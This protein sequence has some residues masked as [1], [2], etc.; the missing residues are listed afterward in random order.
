MYSI[1]SC[2]GRGAALLGLG[3][4]AAM[5]LPVAGPVGAQPPKTGDAKPKRTVYA[6]KNGSAK[7]LAT[8]LGRFF[9][10]EAEIQAVTEGGANVLLI[11]AA[12]AVFDELMTTLAQLDRRP[13]AVA[14]DVWLVDL[15]PHKDKDGQPQ[16]L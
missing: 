2:S 1:P 8:V 12:P 10:G 7:E 15:V 11:N 14:V 9:K 4:A 13:R 3:L 5:A 6:V 16:P